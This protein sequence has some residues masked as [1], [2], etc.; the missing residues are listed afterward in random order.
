MRMECLLRMCVTSAE[1][2]WP[3]TEERLG[4]VLFD[5]RAPGASAAHMLQVLS[6]QKGLAV[7]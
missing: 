4:L 3:E 6:C 1:R 7:Q 2:T 5:R